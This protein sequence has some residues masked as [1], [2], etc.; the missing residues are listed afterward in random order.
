MRNRMCVESQLI[1]LIMSKNGM[2]RVDKFII[3]FITEM[4]GFNSTLRKSL[5]QVGG[6]CEGKNLSVLKHLLLHVVEDLILRQMKLHA[7]VLRF[8]PFSKS[9]CLLTLCKLFNVLMLLILKAFLCEEYDRQNYY[10]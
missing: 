4:D 6:S 8:S 9:C 5:I 2:R 10:G 3:G 1:M 7:S